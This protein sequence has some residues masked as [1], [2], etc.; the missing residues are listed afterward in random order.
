M[1][2]IGV[3][4][5]IHGNPFALEAIIGRFKRENCDLLFCCG[6]LIG[7][8][9]LPEEAAQ[10]VIALKPDVLVEG[11]HELMLAEA[12]KNQIGSG[13]RELEI[14]NHRWIHSKLKTETSNFLKSLPKTVRRE[15]E[16]VKILISHY[17]PEEGHV[18]KEDI[19]LHGHTHSYRLKE[20][21]PMVINL[22]PVGCPHERR[23]I[24]RAGIITVNNGDFSFSPIEEEYDLSPVLDALE[25]LSPPDRDFIKGKF[26]GC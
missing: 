26:F 16:G 22:A 15:I 8:G 5:D 1:K 3:F 23:G 12:L 10:M 7:I 14:E 21:K 4:S 6:D 17:P 18:F 20:E 24:A 9:P 25:R 11:N 13:M 2:K 19:Y